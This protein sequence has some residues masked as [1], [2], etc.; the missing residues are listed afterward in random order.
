MCFCKVQSVHSAV[1]DDP[2]LACDTVL[3]GD[4]F[5]IFTKNCGT[6]T[7]WVKQFFL[8]CLTFVDEDTMILL[9]VWN[10]SPINTVSHLPYMM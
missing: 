3:L 8:D 7:F 2:V 10:Q 4:F 5:S 1:V 6:F 9:R